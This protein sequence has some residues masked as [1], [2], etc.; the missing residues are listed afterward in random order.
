MKLDAAAMNRPL[1]G[2]ARHTFMY[3]TKSKKP[4]N[5][6]ALKMT[7]FIRTHSPPGKANTMNYSK[8][9]SD[10]SLA[11]YKRFKES[12]R[13]LTDYDSMHKAGLLPCLLGYK[14]GDLRALHVY[15][16]GLHIHELNPERAPKSS[17]G[18]S[19]IECFGCEVAND[20][21][22]AET[23]EELEPMLFDFWIPEVFYTRPWLE[24]F[25]WAGRYPED[26]DHDQ[27][28]RMLSWSDR[29]GEYQDIDDEDESLEL[30]NKTIKESVLSV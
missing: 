5:T 21:R 14:L 8:T 6:I 19:V 7:C 20:S 4:M 28:I 11:L 24:Q 23:L 22:T 9:L 16:G 1:N 17:R 15:E 27:R 3:G 12:H 26:F 30:L 29:N 18:V 13:A 25:A 2:G 10:H